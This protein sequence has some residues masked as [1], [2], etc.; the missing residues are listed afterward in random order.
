VGY[1]LIGHVVMSVGFAFLFTPLFTVSMSSVKPS[2]YSHGSAV[3][4]S[5]QQVAGAAGV[6]LFVALMSGR[7][8]LLAARGFA[9]AEALTG[10][11]RV[12]FLCGAVISLFS[13]ACVF[14]VKRPSGRPEMNH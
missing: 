3:I 2:L 13:V 8:A 10:G 9:P 7:S 6:A 4:G 14:F 12:G 1:I 5:V 11:V